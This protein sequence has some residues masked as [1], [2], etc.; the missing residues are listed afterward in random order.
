MGV[1]V[2]ALPSIHREFG[3]EGIRRTILAESLAADTTPLLLCVNMQKGG[4][5]RTRL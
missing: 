1:L 3:L 5:R 4:N 2:V